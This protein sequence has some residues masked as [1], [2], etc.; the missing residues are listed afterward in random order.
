MHPRV[1]RCHAKRQQTAHI[2][3]HGEMH[4]VP[5]WA[6]CSTLTLTEHHL[7]S[8]AADTGSLPLTLTVTR[9]R[10]NPGA[11]LLCLCSLM[12]HCYTETQQGGT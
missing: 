2:P 10:A 1:S 11:R 3:P 8:P 12:F 9:K 6:R 4:T 7:A 5:H